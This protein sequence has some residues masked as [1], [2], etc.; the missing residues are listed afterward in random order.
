MLG[1]LYQKYIVVLKTQGKLIEHLMDTVQILKKYRG[2]LI[3]IMF[4]ITDPVS[5]SKLM[6]KGNPILFN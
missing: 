3:I 6:A 1:Y 5:Y 2:S 4:H